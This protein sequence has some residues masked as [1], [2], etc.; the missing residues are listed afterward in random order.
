RVRTVR[1]ERLAEAEP[2]R[3]V[4]YD[5]FV[6]PGPPRAEPALYLEP[7]A[8]N[9]VCPGRRPVDDAA[10]IDWD[11]DHPAVAGLDGLE[12]LTLEHAVQ[13]V[14]P[15]WGS[16]VVL[17]ATARGAFP[18][19]VAGERDGR[20][21]AC[22]GA[23]LAGPLVSSDDVPFLVLLLSTLRWLEEP[24]GGAALLVET[25]VPALAGSGVAE[26][27]GPG[28]QVAGDPPVLL[29]ERRVTL[30]F[31]VGALGVAYP[32]ALA[33]LLGLPLFFV[34]ASRFRLAAACRA[35]AAALVVLALAGLSLERA[36]PEA[37]TCVVA[38]ID[39]SASVG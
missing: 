10:V 20:R 13:L 7:P 29:A 4:I 19:L 37:G 21:L 32:A 27:H 33:A 16:A 38:A 6:P 18:L 31:G 1:P 24:P 23:D 25:G 17:G 35:L 9:P 34:G 28:L 22:L 2:A 30:P 12:A 14:T 15:G 5:R 36:H 8:G 3:A 39:V 11:V 26:F